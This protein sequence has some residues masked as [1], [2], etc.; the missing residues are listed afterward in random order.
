MARRS[1]TPLGMPL[2][3]GPASPI[4]S[5]VREMRPAGSGQIWHEAEFIQL[6]RQLIGK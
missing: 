5:L 1:G 3:F 4:G 2:E 6:A